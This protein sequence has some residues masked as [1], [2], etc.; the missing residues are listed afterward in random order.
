[1]ASPFPVVLQFLRVRERKP[2]RK[3][4][5]PRALNYYKKVA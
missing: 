1:M 5:T 3:K 2:R 4:S